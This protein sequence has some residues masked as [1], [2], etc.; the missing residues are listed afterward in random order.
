MLTL[1]RDTSPLVKAG[2]EMARRDPAWPIT[3]R[4]IVA[5]GAP[6][7]RR[8][9]E[10]LSAAS[11]SNRKKASFERRSFRS[12]TGAERRLMAVAGHAHRVQVPVGH[13]ADDACVRVAEP[14]GHPSRTDASQRGLRGV[15]RTAGAVL[16]RARDDDAQFRAI[17]SP[18]PLRPWT[19]P[20]ACRLRWPLG[21]PSIGPSVCG[22]ARL[23]EAPGAWY[24]WLTTPVDHLNESRAAWRGY[25]FANLGCRRSRLFF[26]T[27]TFP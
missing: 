5:N 19:V 24:H 7:A 23:L 8:S 21:A 18:P 22:S 17:W 6:A 10:A 14:P 27:W 4:R 15:V 3:L 25:A 1:L 20:G 13:W 2:R 9:R 26:S 16:L 12:D 11:T